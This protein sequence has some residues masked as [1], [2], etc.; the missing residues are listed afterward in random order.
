MRRHGISGPLEAVCRATA[1]P[2]YPVSRA[3]GHASRW[4]WCSRRCSTLRGDVPRAARRGRRSDRRHLRA[5]ARVVFPQPV[6]AARSTSRARSSRWPRSSSPA[7]L[8]AGCWRCPFSTDARNGIRSSGRWSWAAFA[9]ARIGRGEPDVARLKDSPPTRTVNSGRRW[10]SPGIE[11]AHDE[12]CQ[13]C[14]RIGGA[15]NP[16]DETI[17]RTRCRMAASPR[18]ATRR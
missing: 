16:I 4:R 18:R 12:R 9:V 15:A 8:S 2:F 11:F 10:R 14:H 3:Q 5:A 1:Q 7:W 17:A 6:P 13:A